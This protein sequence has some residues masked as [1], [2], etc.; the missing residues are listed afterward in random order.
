[1]DDIRGALA[2][3]QFET[4]SRLAL[5]EVQR[6]RADS[7]VLRVAAGGF[8]AKG[9]FAQA[10]PLLERSRELAPKDA[11]TLLALGICYGK[12][13]RMPS[14][15]ETL[16]AAVLAA[17]DNAQAHASLA[18]NLAAASDLKPAL[19]H[20]R[21]AAAL[22]PNHV[23]AQAG[24]AAVLA[25]VGE[26]EEARVQAYRALALAPENPVAR[27][28]LARADLA[29]RDFAAAEPALRSLTGA[30][31]LDPYLSASARAALGEVLHAQG[32]WDEAFEAFEAT[33]RARTELHGPALKADLARFRSMMALLGDRFVEGWPEFWEHAPEDTGEDRPEI[34]GHVFLMGFPRSGTTLLEQ[35]L[36]A[37][38]GIVALDEAPTLRSAGDRFLR[39]GGTLGELARLDAPTACQFRVAYWR[40]VA[41]AGVDPTGKVFVDKLPLATIS[42]PVIA[43]LFPRAK[44]VFAL[45]DPRDVVLSCFRQDF[46]VNASMYEFLTLKGS[47]RFYDAV[48]R[49]ADGYRDGLKLPLHELYYERL[50]EDFEGEVSSL[51]AFLGLGW[52]DAIRDFADLA[53]RRA[54][55]T[56]SAPQVRRG[57]YRGGAGQWR[58]Y[59][60]QMEGVLPMLA[61]W[62]E[63][64][65]YPAD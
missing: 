38:P 40:E 16:Q 26:N 59:R 18:E 23:D 6:G 64:Y 20:F 55:A 61:P 49:L 29:R 32:R 8:A 17:P 63:R 52:R 50:V 3:G 11:S 58:A 15:I 56:P 31:G 12:L 1:M 48:M 46:V 24:L 57:L 51:L 54:I 35:V 33:N 19:A 7:Q 25:T 62:V 34:A 42:L 47:A 27:F 13:N 41:A 36:A 14:A 21:C 30:T 37:H 9:A 22:S 2:R 43:K 53:A 5:A 10:L 45:R 4:A 65:G 28:A 39:D 44:I 60:A